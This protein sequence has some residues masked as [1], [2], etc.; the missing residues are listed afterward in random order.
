MATPS[1]AVL[2]IQTAELPVQSTPTIKVL[3]ITYSNDLKWEANAKILLHQLGHRISILRTIR[4]LTDFA[5]IRQIATA[6]VIGK[7]S[8]SLPAWGNMTNQLQNWFQSIILTGAR[9]C[10]GHKHNRSST[11]KLLGL[12]KWRSFLQML[13]VQTSSL[14]HQV[15]V[16]GQPKSISSKLTESAAG[17][18]RG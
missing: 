6:T 1:S 17:R 10:L 4:S 16:T 9:I 18:T 13:E 7:I 11:T 2:T 14:I 5:T 15:L 8:Y 3:S 12:M